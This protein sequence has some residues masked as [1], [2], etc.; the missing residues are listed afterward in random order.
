VSAALDWV[1]Q[2]GLSSQDE[3]SYLREYEHV[4]LARILLAQH[5]ADGDPE[6]LAEARGLLE[7]ILAAAEDG[8]RDGTVIEVLALLTLAHRTAGEA[9]LLEVLER[10]LRLAEPEGYVRVFVSEGGL[11]SELLEK[12]SRRRPGWAY[13]RRLLEAARSSGPAKPMAPYAAARVQDGLVEP[14]TGR[15]RDVLRL[16]ATELDGPAIARE[17][18]VSLNTVRTHTKNLYAK[19]GV[20]NRRAAITRAHALNLLGRYHTD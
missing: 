19:L 12:V 10:A 4:T 15:E 16:L 20:T 2:A 13:P 14:L 5:A 1:R 8:G 11:M 9:D 7:R 6:V 3:L 17:L 18:V